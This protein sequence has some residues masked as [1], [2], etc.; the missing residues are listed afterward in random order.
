MIVLKT[1]LPFPI[2][3]EGYVLIVTCSL[4]VITSKFKLQ[5][6]LPKRP[7]GLLKCQ[8]SQFK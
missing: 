2:Q 4:S 8:L 7:F 1:F 5:S 3:V 6:L